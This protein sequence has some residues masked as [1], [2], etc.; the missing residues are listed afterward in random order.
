MNTFSSLS[1]I[2]HC[3]QSGRFHGAYSG[4]SMRPLRLSPQ[5]V[6][7]T[8]LSDETKEYPLEF[9]LSSWK[10][11]GAITSLNRF[12]PLKKKRREIDPLNG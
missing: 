8:V 6:Y 9:I 7:I 3:H 10:S 11:Q 5:E 4:C 2:L 1:C 12:S